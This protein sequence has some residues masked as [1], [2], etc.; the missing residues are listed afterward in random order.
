MDQNR[1]VPDGTEN[2]DDPPP[3]STTTTATGTGDVGDNSLTSSQPSSSS[4]SKTKWKPNDLFLINLTSMGFSSMM[5]KKALYYT[6]NESAEAA[7]EWI[8]T[9]GADSE[10]LPIELEQ[11][12]QQQQSSSLISYENVDDDLYKMVFIVNSELTMGVGK[13]AAQVAHSALGLHRLLLQHQSKYGES[14]LCWNEYGETKI[15]LR[16][17][18]TNHLVELEHKA[19]ALDLPCYMVHDAGKTQV[20]SGSTTVL[21]I[22]GSNKLIDQITGQLKLY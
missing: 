14:L 4:Q 21:A 13:I 15:V 9:N 19:I 22:F 17:E 6:N 11:K 5:A 3:T 10:D 1:G 8:F 7:I 20:K 18:N 12:E 16:G 2:T